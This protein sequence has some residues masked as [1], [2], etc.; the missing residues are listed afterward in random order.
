MRFYKRHKKEE[1]DA[2]RANK[3]EDEKAAKNKS[4]EEKVAERE[5]RRRIQIRKAPIISTLT[6]ILC[7]IFLDLLTYE[8]EKL[9]KERLKKRKT[10]TRKL[11]M[12]EQ[13]FEENFREQQMKMSWNRQH[14][15]L[16]SFFLFLHMAETFYSVV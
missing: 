7:W 13:R 12:R 3:A 16:Y 14:V 15:T 8:Q 10:E 4:H 6:K 1:H 11:E 9:E 5:E 2:R